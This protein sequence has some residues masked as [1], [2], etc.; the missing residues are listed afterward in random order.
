MCNE[1]HIKCYFL[2]ILLHSNSYL[3]KCF[4]VKKSNC[5]FDYNILI[6][7]NS[8]LYMTFPYMHK[9]YFGSIYY[10]IFP[11]IL[12]FLLLISFYFPNIL[13]ILL[14]FKLDM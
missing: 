14:P 1:F 5:I 11:S 4:V 2:M 6:V 7:Q 9:I 13:R 10:S 3:L 8:G 12:F